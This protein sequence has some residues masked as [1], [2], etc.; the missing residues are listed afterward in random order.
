[1]VGSSWASK[2]KGL[3]NREA[4]Q[5]RQKC[6]CQAV[7]FLDF[8]ERSAF[9]PG[10]VNA[11]GSEAVFVFA[12]SIWTLQGDRWNEATNQRH[13]QVLKQATP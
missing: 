5:I 6:R 10:A 12:F 3:D 4:A 7:V 8:G 11:G 1:L 13:R 2:S 9:A